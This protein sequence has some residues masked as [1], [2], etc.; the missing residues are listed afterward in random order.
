VQPSTAGSVLGG[1]SGRHHNSTEKNAL[2]WDN[3]LNRK[4]SKETDIAP[5]NL[6]HGFSTQMKSQSVVTPTIRGNQ[7]KGTLP[8]SAGIRGEA[9]MEVIIIDDSS[10]SD[11]RIE[12]SNN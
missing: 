4:I 8:S 3:R 9:N 5:T 1:L 12:Y 2:T 7:K 11:G 10:D 6:E